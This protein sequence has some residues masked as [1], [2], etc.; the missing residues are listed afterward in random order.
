[1]FQKQGLRFEIPKHY[2]FARFKFKP[3]APEP[4][5]VFH[6][7]GFGMKTFLSRSD[8]FGDADVAVAH[9]IGLSVANGFDWQSLDEPT[10][11]GLARSSDDSIRDYRRHLCQ[12]G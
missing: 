2:E 7:I 6:T 1:V 11:R 10:K 5:R 12:C 8:D 9:G 4:L 3:T